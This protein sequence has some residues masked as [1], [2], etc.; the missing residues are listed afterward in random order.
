M[1]EAETKKK[2]HDHGW[3]TW[4]GAPGNP[5]EI[6]RQCGIKNCECIEKCCY[7]QKRRRKEKGAKIP[8]VLDAAKVEY[9]RL[10]SMYP[11]DKK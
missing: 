1:A 3:M 7:Q 9:K 5:D 11:E 2:E 8:S 6:Y 4:S 10:R